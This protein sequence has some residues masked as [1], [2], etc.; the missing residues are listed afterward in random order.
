MHDG[1]NPSHPIRHREPPC[2]TAAGD[3]SELALAWEHQKKAEDPPSVDGGLMLASYFRRL[4]LTGVAV[5]GFS[6]Q[7]CLG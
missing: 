6:G 2:S 7:E 1:R 5:R 3:S 4:P